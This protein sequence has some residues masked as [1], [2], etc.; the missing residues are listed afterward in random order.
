MLEVN[1]NGLSPLVANAFAAGIASSD[2]T[3]QA[4]KH[5]LRLGHIPPD[6]EFTI[7]DVKWIRDTVDEGVFD[8][9]EARA[10]MHL[11]VARHIRQ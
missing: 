2:P 8:P 11:L 10:I 6:A 3:I 1:S 4:R 5:L 9:N 7:V